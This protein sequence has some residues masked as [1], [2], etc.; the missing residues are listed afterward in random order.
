M[1]INFFKKFWKDQLGVLDGTWV[2]KQGHVLKQP[3]KTRV[4]RVQLYLFT[5]SGI[6]GGIEAN[7]AENLH[8]QNRGILSVPVDLLCLLTCWLK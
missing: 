3:R 5:R 6:C 7:F 4:I 2:F 1:T 8:Q